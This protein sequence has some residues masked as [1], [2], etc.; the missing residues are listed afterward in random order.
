V[1]K[2]LGLAAFRAFSLSEECGILVQGQDYLRVEKVVN[3]AIDPTNDF[4]ISN[5][6]VMKVTKML[7]ENESIVGF[8]HTHLPHHLAIPSEEDIYAASQNSGMRH[9]VFHPSTNELTWYDGTGE[10]A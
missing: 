8:F 5:F 7:R 6:A 3:R 10:L 2:I 9:V 1:D 4:V